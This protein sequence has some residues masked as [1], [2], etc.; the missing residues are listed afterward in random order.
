M[1][2]PAGHDQGI[3]VGSD[4]E[5]REDLLDRADEDSLGRRETARHWRT[6]CGR[7]SPRRRNRPGPPGWPTACPTCP[8]PTMTSRIRGSVGSKATPPCTAG[9]GRSVERRDP[10]RPGR[11]GSGPRASLPGAS[12][13]DRTGTAGRPASPRARSG[14]TTTAS[15]NPSPGLEQAVERAEVGERLGPLQGL[16]DDHHLAAADQTV[17]PGVIVIEDERL[18]HRPGRHRAAGWRSASPRSR[19]SRRRACRPGRRPGRR[20]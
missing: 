13:R 2:V 3:G 10:A 4:L 7:R 11:P 8:A 15:V 9:L 1:A 5:R 20:P 19:R 17:G 6:G 14:W 18:E 16:G 12:R